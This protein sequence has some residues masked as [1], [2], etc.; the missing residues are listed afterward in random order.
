MH[1][2]C[3]NGLSKLTTILLQ[4]GANPNLQTFAP[5]TVVSAA[6]EEEEV[7]N[8]QTPLHLAILGQHE[9]T[10]QAVIDHK[11]KSHLSWKKKNHK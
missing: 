8:Q 3:S 10:I 4:K 5:E 2:S 11:G 9:E 7:V 6:F 1:I